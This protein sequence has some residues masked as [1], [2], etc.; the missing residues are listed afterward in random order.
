MFHYAKSQIIKF[1]QTL[2]VG[3]L[4]QL[5]IPTQYDFKINFKNLEKFNLLCCHYKSWIFLF[6]G[7]KMLA[8]EARSFQKLTWNMKVLA[9]VVYLFGKLLMCIWFRHYLL[10]KNFHH[11]NPFPN[12]FLPFWFSNAQP[13]NESVFEAFE[14]LML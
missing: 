10:I 3:Q 5:Q 7:L 8:C 6:L 14:C 11:K 4:K 1:M 13:E 2:V 9:L 12:T